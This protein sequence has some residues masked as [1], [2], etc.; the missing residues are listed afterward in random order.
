MSNSKTDDLFVSQPVVGRRSGKTTIH[1]T[2]RLSNAD[3]SFAG[4][5]AASIDPA[6]LT[7]FYETIDIGK[8]GIVNLVGLDGFVRAARGFKKDVKYFNPNSGLLSRLHAAP[9]GTFISAGGADGVGRI[10]SY[11]KVAGLPLVVIVGLGEHEALASYYRDVAIYLLV[12]AALTIFVL[13]VIALSTRHG[14]KLE[15]AY[16]WLRRSEAVAHAK[17]IELRTTL[18]NI[19]QGIIMVDADGTIQVINRRS[20]ELLDIPES[21][22][23]SGTQAQGSAGVPLGPRRIREQRF[24]PQ[25]PRHAQ[26]RRALY[27]D[28]LL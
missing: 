10:A 22:M 9:T 2:R 3:G 26:K 19:D 14:L 28:R 25:S 7:K 4:M 23:A 13:I 11:R 5:I 1:L 20:I 15:R 6:Q 27:R 24:R 18:E 16:G 12:G 8:D 21:W 17:R